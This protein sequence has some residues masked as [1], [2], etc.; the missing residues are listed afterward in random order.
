MDMTRAGGSVRLEF[1][2]S[3]DPD[4]RWVRAKGE[5]TRFKIA[6]DLLGDGSRILVADKP[7]TVAVLATRPP[8]PHPGLIVR[9]VMLG[10][11][12]SGEVRRI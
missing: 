6:F 12:V 7:A 2:L 4:G 11:K 5:H 8:E 3:G 9:P 10:I 1:Y